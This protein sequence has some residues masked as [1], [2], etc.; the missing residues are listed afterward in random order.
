MI[1]ACIRSEVIGRVDGGTGAVLRLLLDQ[2]F[3]QGDGHNLSRSGIH[4]VDQ[5]GNH[6]YVFSNIGVIIGDEPAL[7][8]LLSAKGHAGRQ[9]SVA[10]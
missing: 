2:F 9:A 5:D 8:Q 10:V 1:V 6:M 7:A 4:L 3:F